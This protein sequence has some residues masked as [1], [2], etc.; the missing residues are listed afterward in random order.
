MVS[1]PRVN[2][3]LNLNMGLGESKVGSEEIVTDFLLSLPS[4]FHTLMDLL[5]IQIISAISPTNP[6]TAEIGKISC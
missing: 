1:L 3:Y 5:D 2:F 6:I 4:D